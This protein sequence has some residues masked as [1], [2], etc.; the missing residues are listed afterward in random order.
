MET[1]EKPGQRIRR[2][3]DLSVPEGET[4]RNGGRRRRMWEGTEE[5]LRGGRLVR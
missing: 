2:S 4:H 5:D 1:R 3:E